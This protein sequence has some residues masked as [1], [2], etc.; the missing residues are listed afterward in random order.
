M[1]TVSKKVNKVRDPDKPVS[2]Y[3]KYR[4]ID[5][6][7]G[8]ASGSVLEIHHICYHPVCDGRDSSLAPII[9]K[10]MY[11]GRQ[12]DAEMVDFKA[13]P[14]NFTEYE[15]ADGTNLRIKLVLLE[16]LR[17]IG[18]YNAT[19]GDPIYVFQA[20]QLIGAHSP[21]NLKKKPN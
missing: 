8:Y 16:V 9:K 7:T 12:V 10:V 19:T 6:N 20:Q 15:L 17:V 13:A 1:D 21:E 5:A 18:E 14:E 4:L 2:A 3:T 11:N